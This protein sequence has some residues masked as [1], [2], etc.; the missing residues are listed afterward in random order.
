VGRLL[1]L[2]HPPLPRQH[3]PRPDRWRQDK[4]NKSQ[5]NTAR[6]P[7]GRSTGLHRVNLREKIRP[8]LND[9]VNYCVL[10][11]RAPGYHRPKV[12]PRYLTSNNCSETARTFAQ[13]HELV[14][15]HRAAVLPVILDSFFRRN[16]DRK[17]HFP[18]CHS[19]N[20]G[21]VVIIRSPVNTNK[22]N[23]ID[24][25]VFLRYRFYRNRKLPGLL[26]PDLQPRNDKHE[27]IPAHHAVRLHLGFHCRLWALPMAMPSQAGYGVTSNRDVRND[28]RSSLRA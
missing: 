13:D 10:D 3:G 11:E 25:G 22:T 16:D 21:S 5:L 9:E 1:L 24:G 20:Y 26:R 19:G 14:K 28:L 17:T 2:V 27:W 8:E 18:F 6:P 12:S 4:A 7:K 23:F 15:W